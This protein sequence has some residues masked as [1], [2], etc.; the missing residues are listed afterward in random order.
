MLFTVMQL[1]SPG[2]QV[3]SI[4]N[5][6]EI[7]PVQEHFSNDTPAVP[8]SIIVSMINEKNM[9]AARFIS[10]TKIQKKYISIIFHSSL[11]TFFVSL[12]SD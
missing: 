11:F 1:P 12:Q 9:F 7:F 8:K 5:A 10:A 3:L 6:N 2:Q 4:G